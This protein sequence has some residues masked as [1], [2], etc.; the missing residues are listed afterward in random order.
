V[1]GQPLHL[2]PGPLITRARRAREI[3]G[4]VVHN[5]AADRFTIISTKRMHTQAK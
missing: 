3:D 5:K 4:L 1:P 2:T